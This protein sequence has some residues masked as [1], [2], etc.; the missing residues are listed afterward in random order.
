MR[1]K[2]GRVFLYD[3]KEFLSD[4]KS[5]VSS[6]VNDAEHGGSMIMNPDDRVVYADYEKHREFENRTVIE[7]VRHLRNF[8]SDALDTLNIPDIKNLRNPGK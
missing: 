6:L 4:A 8:I 5:F 7:A 2:Q 1:T 3:F